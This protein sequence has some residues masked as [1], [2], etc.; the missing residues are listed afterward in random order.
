MESISNALSKR[1]K[2]ISKK[3]ASVSLDRSVDVKD[4]VDFERLDLEIRFLVPP[5]AALHF[6]AWEDS[7]LW[8]C[9]RKIT[10]RTGLDF[11]VEFHTEAWETPAEVIVERLETTMALRPPSGTENRAHLV[12]K[13]RSVWSFANADQQ[14][15]KGSKHRGHREQDCR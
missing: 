9:M 15:G 8:L 5:G 2:A 6:T 1:H 4:G 7:I 13:I 12:D 11:K 10:K 14:S 3:T